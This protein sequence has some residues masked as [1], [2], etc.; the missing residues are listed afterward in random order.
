MGYVCMHVMRPHYSEHQHKQFYCF[1]CSWF[2][3]F[4]SVYRVEV[5]SGVES[6][7]LPFITTLRLP[8]EMKVTWMNNT[9]R[10]VHRDQRCSCSSSSL[11]EQHWQYRDRTEMKK[12][13]NLGDF[14]LILKNPT[15]R[16]T[17][18]YTCTISNSSGKVLIEKKVLLNVKGQYNWYKPHFIHENSFNKT[19]VFI[20]R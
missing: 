8:K 7:L 9:G 14:S 19:R 2:V 10:I 1:H 13:F 12:T 5:D 17:G 3:S 20:L 6:V 4:S 18:T 15:D 11:E 16:D